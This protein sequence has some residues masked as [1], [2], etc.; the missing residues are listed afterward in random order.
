MPWNAGL[1]R[2]RSPARRFGGCA[3]NVCA[4]ANRGSDD[5]D[6]D[7]PESQAFVESMRAGPIAPVP[8]KANEQHYEL[9]PEFF[10]AVLGPHRKYSSLLLADGDDHVGRSRSGGARESPASEPISPMARRFWNSAAAGVRCRCGWPNGIA[11]SRI[12]AVSNS[13]PQR[14][15]IEAE[16]A[17]RGLTNLHVITADMNDFTP[18]S[19]SLRPRRLGGDVRAHAELRTAAGTNRVVAAT[20]RQTV[21]ASFLPSDARVSVRNRRRCELDGPLLL[22][23][24]LDAERTHADDNSTG[25]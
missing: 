12:T 16:A 21:R 25:T 1:S 4:N 6:G 14:R 5:A 20:G 22:H 18:E 24:R 9:P 7:S 19:A 3:S 17:S 23:R 13:A 8:E 2:M 11:S 10:A 15:F